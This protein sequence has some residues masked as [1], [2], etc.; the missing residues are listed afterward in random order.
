LPRA[1]TLARAAAKNKNINERRPLF[2]YAQTRIVHPGARRN[3]RTVNVARAN[4]TAP[5]ANDR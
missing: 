4:L 5:R 1:E 3:G 2:P